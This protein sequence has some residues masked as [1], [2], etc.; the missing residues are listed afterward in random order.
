MSRGT[1]S[2]SRVRR[3]L[4]FGVGTLLLGLYLYGLDYAVLIDLARSFSLGIAAVVIALNVLPGGIKYFRWRYLLDRRGLGVT[5]FRG[6]LAV[7]ASFFLGL[8]TPGTAGELSRAWVS[9][10][11]EAG[12]A[13]AVVVFEKLTDFA[14]LLLLVAGSAAVQFTEGLQ[15]W[16][17]VAVAGVGVA[18]LYALFL[19]YDA[20]LTGPLKYVLSRALSDERRE[21]LRE[22]YWEFYEL[23]QDRRL[24]LISA[25]ASTAL[26]L[27]TLVQM[28]LIFTGLGWTLPL[29]TTA[30]AL[31][32]P[33]LLGVVSFIPMGLGV[34]ELVMSRVTEIGVLASVAGGTAIGPLFFRLLVTLPLVLGGYASHLALTLRP[35][36]EVR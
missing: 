31:F 25:V 9:E 1:G 12:R 35:R 14:I 3:G 32:L 10:S 17:I 24:V 22:A 19:R 26:W 5:G 13:T 29:K 6:Y 18:G 27:V 28:H 23:L 11:E 7:N 20:L 2:G 16:G 21:S 30:L 34:F 36:R 8:V 15:S 4:L 33:Y